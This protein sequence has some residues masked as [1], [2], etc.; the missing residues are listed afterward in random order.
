M[1]SGI[2]LTGLKKFMDGDIDLLVDDINAALVTATYAP[3]FTT[4]EFFDDI[5]NEIAGG[6][7]VAG[8][9]T[10]GGKTTTVDGGNSR[11]EFDA[12]D[13]AAWDADTFTDVAGIVV[14]MDTGNDATSPLIC[15]IEVSPAQDAPLTLIWN[16]EGIF[17]IGAC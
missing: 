8:G 12:N 13:I 2:Y 4:H 1:A 17:Y 11:T 10:L 14:Y 3:N 7:Y 16:A 9:E 6:G 15:F 5:T